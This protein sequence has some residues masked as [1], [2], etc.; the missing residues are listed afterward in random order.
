M[1]DPKDARNYVD[2]T[3][4]DALA[5]AIGNAHGF[6]KGEPNL[7]IDRLKAIGRAVGIPLVLH[8]GTGI[9]QHTLQQAINA[10]ISK[11]NIATQLFDAFA[12][13]YHDAYRDLHDPI[14]VQNAFAPAMQRGQALVQ[15]KITIFLNR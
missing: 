3:G 8:G 7:D 15:H 10:G 12:K 5:V 1:T 2:A 11:I 13:G 9:P 14:N 6:Y 4:V